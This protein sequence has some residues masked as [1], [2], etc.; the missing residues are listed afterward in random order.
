MVCLVNGCCLNLFCYIDINVGIRNKENLTHLVS[1]LSLHEGEENQPS[2]HHMLKVPALI[3]VAVGKDMR[4]VE[5]E[6]A[7]IGRDKVSHQKRNRKLSENG[8]CLKL[9]TPNN[10]RGKMNSKLFIQP[11]AIE[12]LM[13]SSRNY[14][15]S[16]R[17]TSR[18]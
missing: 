10:T 9:S 3:A 14:F 11:G 6:N 2:N 18:V 17:A 13:Y 12:G 7:E 8:H 16:R 4:N 1:S 5:D 15:D